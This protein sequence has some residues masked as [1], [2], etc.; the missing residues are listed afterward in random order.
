MNSF[1]GKAIIEWQPYNYENTM[2]FNYMYSVI[3]EK[4]SS[5]VSSFTTLIFFLTAV[6]HVTLVHLLPFP[7]C[8]R[9]LFRCDR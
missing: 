8:Q 6:G 1:Y 4:K 5:P 9:G 7:G 2:F 3:N